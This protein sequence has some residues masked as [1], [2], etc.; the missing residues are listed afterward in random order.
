MDPDKK[1]EEKGF[2][3]AVPE[4]HGG[5]QARGQIG[6]AAA[7]YNTATATWDPSRVCNL[8]RSSWQRQTLNPLS[9][10]RGPTCVLM[11]TSQV[12]YR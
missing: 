11:D 6:A 8:H 9:G 1:E 4:A 10:A 12:H 7:G 3:G 5:S 2:W